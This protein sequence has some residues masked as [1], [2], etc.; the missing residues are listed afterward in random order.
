MLIYIGSTGANS[1]MTQVFY[2]NLKKAPITGNS[3]LQ[4][5]RDFGSQK[6][7]INKQENNFNINDKS[8]LTDLIKNNS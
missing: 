8:S 3:H 6:I 7:T 5:S 1:E 4:I 2:F